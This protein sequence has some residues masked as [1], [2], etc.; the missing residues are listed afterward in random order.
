[1]SQQSSQSK[2]LNEND[3]SYEIIAAALEVHTV[4]GPGLLERVY[5]ETLAHELGLRGF[6]VNR[7]VAI[8]V[9]YKSLQIDPAYRADLIVNNLVIIEVKSVKTIEDV[10]LKQLLT[11]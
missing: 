1:M 9:A 5:E 3:L 8:H 2:Y 10:F 4:L 7:Q 6:T 11:G